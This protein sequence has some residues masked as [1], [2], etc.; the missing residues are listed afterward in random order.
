MRQEYHEI[1]RCSRRSSGRIVP[2]RTFRHLTALTFRTTNRESDMRPSLANRH[3]RRIKRASVQPSFWTWPRQLETGEPIP[4]SQL[5]Q[6]AIP[7]LSAQLQMTNGQ[8][9][10]ASIRALSKHD[11]VLNIPSHRDV[12][13]RGQV[14]DVTVCCA[15]WN[16]VTSQMCVLHWAGIINGT[17]VVAGFVLNSPGVAIDQPASHKSRNHIRFPV[18]LPAMVAIDSD[19]DVKGQIVDYSLSGLR[20]V[21]EEPIELERDYTVSVNTQPSCVQLT[22]RPRWVLDTGAGHQMGCTLPAE[23]GVLLTCRFHAQPT[24]LPTPLRPQTTNWNGTGDGDDCN[25]LSDFELFV[26]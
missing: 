26:R 20:L 10:D 18:N 17:P 15:K 13:V 5:L 2:V 21:T 14:V 1:Q 25:D 22:V 11:I 8:T 6:P 3:V 24:G 19:Q 7:D 12:P 4:D 16:V 23:Q 9:V